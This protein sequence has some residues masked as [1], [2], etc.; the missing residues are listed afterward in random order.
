M[1]NYVLLVRLSKFVWVGEVEEVLNKSSW[2]K[3]L[4]FG[5]GE[6]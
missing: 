3:V 5:L 1:N 4:G 2:V 6:L